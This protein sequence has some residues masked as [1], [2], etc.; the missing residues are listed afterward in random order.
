MNSRSRAGVQNRSSSLP[1][2]FAN[3]VVESYGFCCKE[4]TV[5]TGSLDRRSKIPA[6]VITVFRR[7]FMCYE[8]SLLLVTNPILRSRSLFLSLV[9]KAKVWKYTPHHG[10]ERFYLHFQT[11][12]LQKRKRK[13]AFKLLSGRSASQGVHIISLLFRR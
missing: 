6:N 3:S 9:S 11:K 7:L 1:H 5:L 10:S 12:T 8:H 4:T 13:N 2:L